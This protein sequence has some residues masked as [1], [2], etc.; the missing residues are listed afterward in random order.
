MN[1]SVIH[2]P[3]GRSFSYGELAAS[4]AQQKP[5]ENPPLKDPKEFRLIGKPIKRI[6]GGAIVTGRATYGLDVQIQG[7][8]YAVVARSP[9]IGGK[10]ASSDERRAMRVAG[11]RQVV[12]VKTGIA[13][14]VAVVA[15]SYL[16]GHEG[17]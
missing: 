7:M 15:D 10:V 16:G 6:D 9:F 13:T 1:G 17:T 14:G 11:V 2:G 3:T 5:P 12:P 8:K 4:A